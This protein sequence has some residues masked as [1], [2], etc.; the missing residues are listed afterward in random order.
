MK[1][2]NKHTL[3]ICAAVAML[4][5]GSCILA[6][7]SS[8]PSSSSQ[9]VQTMNQD[10]KVFRYGVTAYTYENGIDP[11]VGY[12]GWSAIR[13][14]IGETLFRFTN[15]MELEP[16]L[17]TGYEQLDDYTVKISLRDDV[18]FHNGKKMTGESVKKCLERLIQM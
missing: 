1:L 12:A 4:A 6:G 16:W 5:I 14:G 17:A 2:R 10:E 7:C 3:K 13:Y 18:T 9:T 15:N 11:H 8:T